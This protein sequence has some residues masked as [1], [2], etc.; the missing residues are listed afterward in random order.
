MTATGWRTVVLLALLALLV[1]TL[2]SFVAPTGGRGGGAR[3]SNRLAD[4]PFLVFR[5]LAPGRWFGRLAVLPLGTPDRSL[6]F[7]GLPC[8]RAHYAAGRGICIVQE[9]LRSTAQHAAYVIDAS[10]T[11]GRRVPLSGVPTR[12]RIAPDGRRAAITTFAEEETAAGER[13]ATDSI[14]VDLPTGRVIARLRDFNVQS[15]GPQ[16]EGP[17]DI[18]G[19][20]FESDGDRFFAA[21]TTG[22]TWYLLS[23][24]LSKREMTALRSGV[25]SE[26]ISPDGRHLVVKKRRDDGFWQLAVL[27]LRTWN[28][29]EL[30]QGGR[31]VDDQVEWLDDEHVVYHDADEATTSIWMLP[32]DGVN[33]PRVL[34]RDAYSPAVQR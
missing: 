29:R 1:G 4:P 31:S 24:S 18:A 26:S 32:I 22:T 28:E 20:A 6:Q 34:V 21:G 19:V 7:T 30:Q 5:T 33:G 10:F 12:V 23:G 2:V 17:I 14:V 9:Q 16:L 27:D 13:L 3:R 15:D 11:R 8:V 25:A